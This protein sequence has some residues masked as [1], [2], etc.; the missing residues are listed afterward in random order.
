VR[1]ILAVPLLRDGE[2][3]G[4]IVLLNSIVKPFTQKQ[5]DLVN[6]FANQA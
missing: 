5:I 4:V 2:A 1:A 6:T 3:V